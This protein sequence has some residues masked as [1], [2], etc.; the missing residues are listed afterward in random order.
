[1]TAILNSITYAISTASSFSESYFHQQ[2]SR[3]PSIYTLQYGELP[4]L[5]LPYR[6]LLCLHCLSQSACNWQ[7]SASSRSVILTAATKTLIRHYQQKWSIRLH[8]ACQPSSDLTSWQAYIQ[9]YMGFASIILDP[10]TSEGTG[11]KFPVRGPPMTACVP[12]PGVFA[13]RCYPS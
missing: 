13:H 2:E 1:M 5:S 12:R 8:R 10:R 7:W 9:C 6:L 11:F 4:W 3:N